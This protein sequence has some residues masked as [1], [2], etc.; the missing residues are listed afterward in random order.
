MIYLTVEQFS[1]TVPE[2][3]HVATDWQIATD[4]GFENIIEDNQNDTVNL[5]TYLSSVPASDTPVYGRARFRLYK[6]TQFIGFTNWSIAA[7]CEADPD[8]I[9]KPDLSFLCTSDNVSRP[10]VSAI[11]LGEAVNPPIVTISDTGYFGA[12]FLS[13]VGTD[14]DS[15]SV[16]DTHV[17]TDWLVYI[18][19]QENIPSATPIIS[20]LQDNI[21]LT[22]YPVQPNT[23]LSG[24]EYIA[25]VK[26][27]GSLVSS[28]P[29]YFEFTVPD[30]DWTVSNTLGISIQHPTN[31]PPKMIAISDDEVFFIAWNSVTGGDI[32][33]LNIAT[34]TLTAISNP[35]IANT[36]IY[37]GAVEKLFDGRIMVMDINGD[38]GIYDPV[39]DSWTTV[40]S[41]SV[42]DIKDIALLSY[43]NDDIYFINGGRAFLDNRPLGNSLVNY[44]ISTDTWTNLLQL[45]NSNIPAPGS[46]YFG[47][48]FSFMDEDSGTG[49]RYIKMLPKIACN[50]TTDRYVLAPGYLH[51]LTVANNSLSYTPTIINYNVGS[52]I[53]A[54]TDNVNFIGIRD[55]SASKLNDRII[56]TGGRDE[57]GI[58]HNSVISLF[59]S[60]TIDNSLRALPIPLYNHYQTVMPDGTLIVMG[61]L[62]LNPITG[63]IDENNKIFSYRF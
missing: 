26:Y 47:S 53:D 40:T 58:I 31:T 1:T 51:S 41:Y 5:V 8:K 38:A 30:I 3:Y 39:A 19:G 44:N 14:F 9:H 7:Q 50:N 37:F 24:V 12:G 49:T 18:K 6:N 34:G 13:I 46:L 2:V 27:Y 23:L 25:I 59:L 61:G 28:I 57:N 63:N 36:S 17:S 62:K 16:P 11:D 55:F 48:N 35:F 10:V 56:V 22:E 4:V 54:T 45:S 60:G 21:N 52:T 43:N 42:S 33:N 32:Y 20:S 15:P 29:V